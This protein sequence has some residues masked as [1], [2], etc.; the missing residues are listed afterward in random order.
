M[1][2][3][4]PDG[5]PLY[6]AKRLRPPALLSAVERAQQLL[7]A[8][9]ACAVGRLGREVPLRRTQTASTPNQVMDGFNERLFG[10]PTSPSCPL[11]DAAYKKGRNYWHD[12]NNQSL[13]DPPGNQEPDPPEFDWFTFARPGRN[14]GNLLKKEDPRYVPLF[15]TP[16]NSFTG[17]GNELH[18]I[19]ADR[20]LLHHR[21]RTHP[22]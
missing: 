18:P 3:C 1:Q 15:M 4:G 21:V 19:V 8:P 9:E 17:S 13:Y 16:Y 11:D 14:H 5:D 22:R 6:A 2:G 12:E 7:H 20:L 10:D